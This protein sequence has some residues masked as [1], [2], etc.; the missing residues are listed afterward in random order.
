LALTASKIGRLLVSV[1]AGL[2]HGSS[3]TFVHGLHEALWIGAGVA[4]VGAVLAARLTRIRSAVPDTQSLPAS[5][6]IAEPA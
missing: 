6:A 2:G 4:A 3:A 1:G 5:E